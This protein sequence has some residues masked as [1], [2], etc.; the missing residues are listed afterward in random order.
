MNALIAVALMR[1]TAAQNGISE[2]TQKGTTL[3]FLLSEFDP[4]RVSV[5]CGQEKYKTRVVLSA[6][7]K[8][9]LTLR[10]KKGEDALR[11]GTKLVEDYAKTA[12]EPA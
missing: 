2:I 6:G 9:C 4:R 8:P 7:E 12:A 1:A 10:L 5:L 3:S 11:W